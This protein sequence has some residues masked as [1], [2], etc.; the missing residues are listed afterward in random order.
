MTITTICSGTMPSKDEVI[1]NILWVARLTD[2]WIVPTLVLSKSEPLALRL[3]G[4][5]CQ[6]ESWRA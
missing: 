4:A 6:A 3:R 2:L 5:R 1:H